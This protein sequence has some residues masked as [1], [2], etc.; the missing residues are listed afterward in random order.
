MIDGELAHARGDERGQPVA[1]PKSPTLVLVGDGPVELDLLC[2]VAPALTKLM[3]VRR[4]TLE[5]MLERL[6]RAGFAGFGRPSEDQYARAIR[7][8]PA[9]VRDYFAA[10]RGGIERRVRALL[11]AV[12]PTRRA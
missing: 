6:D 1:S 9:V 2:E 8:D 12:N 3:G 11:P 4:P 5:T 7:R 10:T